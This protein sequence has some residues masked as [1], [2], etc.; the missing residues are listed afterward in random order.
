MPQVVREHRCVE[1]FDV[2]LM[3][4]ALAAG[5]VLG[6]LLEVWPAGHLEHMA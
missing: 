5:V 3:E 2:F 6:Q 1:G 4:P